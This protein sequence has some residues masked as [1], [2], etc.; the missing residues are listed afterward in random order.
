[1]LALS[2][3][4]IN[5][6]NREGLQRTIDSVLAQTWKDFE[7]IVIDGRSTEGSREL[8]EQY[9]KHFAYW[10]HISKTFLTFCTRINIKTS[11]VLLLNNLPMMFR[12]ML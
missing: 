3:I 9:Q 12:M 2:I 11:F 10:C 6:N 5:Y 4:N 7:W 1:M 8:T